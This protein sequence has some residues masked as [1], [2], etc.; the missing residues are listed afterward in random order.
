MFPVYAEIVAS[1]QE[2]WPWGEVAT[3]EEVE[4][5]LTGRWP[6]NLVEAAIWKLVA[7]A[8][9][10]GHLLVELSQQTLHR[11]LPLALLP[12][13]AAALLPPPLPDTLLSEP[14]TREPAVPSDKGASL[15]S[16]TFD[17]SHLPE[18][19]REH[20]YRNWRAVSQVLAGATQTRVAEESGISRSTLSHLVRRTRQIGQI[21]CVP[22]G[23][24]RRTTSM[25]SAERVLFGNISPGSVFGHERGED[26]YVFQ[27]QAYDLGRNVLQPVLEDDILC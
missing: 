7:D 20:F 21:A 25:F 3:V 23:S 4:S 27:H 22:H 9:A 14:E 5:R 6:A 17:P 16:P 8:A 2:I 1:V 18:E 24:Y 10:A 26:G 13:N 15:P 11:Q 19:Q 12:P